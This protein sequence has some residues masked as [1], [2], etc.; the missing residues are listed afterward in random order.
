MYISDENDNEYELKVYGQIVKNNYVMVPIANYIIKNKKSRYYYVDLD[1]S[2]VETIFLS[3]SIV[4]SSFT[5]YPISF[6]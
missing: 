5:I 3:K 6:K 1:T 2:D 4:E